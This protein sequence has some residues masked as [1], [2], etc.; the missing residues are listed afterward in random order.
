MPKIKAKV[1]HEFE[2]ER[3]IQRL[4]QNGSISIFNPLPISFPPFFGLL[5]LC[6]LKLLLY[7]RLY[8]L[9]IYLAFS[10]SYWP[11]VHLQ[12]HWRSA[13]NF[14]FRIFTLAA[15]PVHSELFQGRSSSEFEVRQ[16]LHLMLMPKQT[17][18]PFQHY[19]FNLRE[20]LWHSIW[21]FLSSWPMRAFRRPCL[22]HIIFLNVLAGHRM[23]NTSSVVVVVVQNM[24]E[25]TMRWDP[26]CARMCLFWLVSSGY[27]AKS[28]TK[29][30]SQWQ[31]F[32]QPWR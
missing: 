25:F 24:K 30:W 1:R 31:H 26:R 15:P 10:S 3:D 18:E 11:L 6:K 21:V 13:H 9:C 7:F 14:L 4:P 29:N 16:V 5:C 12:V 20:H 23:L 22:V 17:S 19:I 8:F 28:E 2:I 32:L 27:S